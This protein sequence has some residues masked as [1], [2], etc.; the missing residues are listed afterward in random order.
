MLKLYLYGYLQQIRSSRR[1]ESECQR[2]VELMWLLGRLCPDHKITIRTGFQRYT[3]ASPSPTIITSSSQEPWSAVQYF[4]PYSITL[5]VVSGSLT[6]AIPSFSL[7][8]G[9]IMVPAGGTVILHSSTTRTTNVA[10]SSAV[11]D[12]YEGVPACA[13]SIALTNP[14][15]TTS[16][17]A[18]LTVTAGNTPAFCHFTVTGNDS[19]GTSTQGGWIVVGN[20]AASLTITGGNNQRLCTE[21]L[22][23]WRLR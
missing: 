6:A 21:R 16:Q 19:S 5:V 2:N 1:L 11:F 7:N 18:L 20:P 3:L 8:P 9:A 12:A 4:P 17:P 15:I 22:C 10:L 23:R 14:T 13:G